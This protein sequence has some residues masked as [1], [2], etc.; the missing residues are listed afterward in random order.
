M[1]ER[2][3]NPGLPGGAVVGGWGLKPLRFPIEFS[4]VCARLFEKAWDTERLKTC[5][6]LLC[7]RTHMLFKSRKSK[8]V[9]KVTGTRATVERGG[10]LEGS[11]VVLPAHHHP[12][13]PQ[14]LEVATFVFRGRTEACG[15][16]PSH[17]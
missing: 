10:V 9:E 5:T 13:V 14:S 7:F 3:L 15:D 4:C 8:F 6:A 17:H 11:P 1:P 2:L 16:W 12:Y